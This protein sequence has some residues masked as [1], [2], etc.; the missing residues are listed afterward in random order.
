MRSYELVG[1]LCNRK[2]ELGM[3]HGA[4]EVRLNSEKPN[5]LVSLEENLDITCVCIAEK[6]ING[7]VY[8]KVA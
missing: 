3:F 5:W 8:K 2:T 6:W 7:W 4:G 1:S